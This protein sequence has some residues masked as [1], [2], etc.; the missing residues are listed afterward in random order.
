[1]ENYIYELSKKAGIKKL[2]EE[3]EKTYPQ[4]KVCV[5][6]K[7]SQRAMYIIIADRCFHFI[8]AYE[9]SDFDC[10]PANQS[11]LPYG[12]DKLPQSDKACDDAT[13]RKFYLQFMKNN[14]ETYRDD[15]IKHINEL[16][17]EDLGITSSL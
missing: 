15:Y 4:V 16:A 3:I 2:E 9:A 1:M 12:I 5:F 13:I 8:K 17:D 11:R 10:V 14:F 6:M 7:A